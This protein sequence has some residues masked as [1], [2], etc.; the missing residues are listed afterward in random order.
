MVMPA[1][2]TGLDWLAVNEVSEDERASLAEWYAVTH[3]MDTGSSELALTGFVDFWLRERPDVLKAYRRSIEA[4]CGFG[5]ALPAGAVGLIFLHQYTMVAYESGVLYEVIAS[6]V[7]GASRAQVIETLAL[8]FLH[9]GPHGMSVATRSA[10]SYLA[11]WQVD[12][13]ESTIDWPSGWSFDE[14]MLRSG[15]DFSVMELTDSDLR[16]LKAWH[17]RME[18]EVP[19][20][21]DFLAERNPQA[22][23]AFRQRFEHAIRGALPIQM[24][25]LFLLHTA[26]VRGEKGAL[27]RAMHM[28]QQMQIEE[29]LVNHTLSLPHIYVGHVSWDPIVA[30]VSPRDRSQ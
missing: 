17:E 14:S 4:T 13:D 26:A 16:S 23:K 18:G 6:R 22:L 8:A 21:V 24:V 1:F 9:G 19:A 5:D 15:V 29:R 20:Y 30:S 2:S 10:G 25:A 7:W 12:G 3:E 27:R 28:A 11:E